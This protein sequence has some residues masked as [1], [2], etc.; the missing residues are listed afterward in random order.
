MAAIVYS[1]GTAEAATDLGTY[2]SYR[3]SNAVDGNMRTKFYS[4]SGT[5]VG[6]YVRVDLKKSIPLYDLKI[7]Y[8]PNPK[9]LQEGVDG[10]RQPKWK[11]PPMP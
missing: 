1:I 2:G 4:S 8:A 9:G 11:F 10:L 3:I 5:S 6:S 7:C